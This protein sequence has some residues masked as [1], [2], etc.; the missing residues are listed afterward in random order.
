MA[1]EEHSGLDVVQ[2][3]KQNN[4]AYEGGPHSD[5]QDGPQSDAAGDAAMAA[6]LA[7][8]EVHGSAEYTN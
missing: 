6:H 5:D 2:E 3:Y 8:A 7:D 1:G 4:D